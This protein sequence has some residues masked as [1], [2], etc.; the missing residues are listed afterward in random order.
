MKR[1]IPHSQVT[2]YRHFESAIGFTAELSEDVYL[3]PGGRI[4]FDKVVSNIGGKY[5]DEHGFFEGPDDSIYSFTISACFPE[6]LDQSLIT[7]LVFDRAVV[8][9]DQLLF[10]QQH[11]KT[12]VHHL[13]QFSF[14][15]SKAKLYMWKLKIHTTSRIM[16]MVLDL[17]H[18]LVQDS[19][20]LTVMI[21]WH[22]LLS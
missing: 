5:C 20:P 21:M 8:K 3:F 18:S 1:V 11:Q 10:G 9:W 22:S 13:L 14:T 2:A 16:S 19:V 6:Y 12:A 17:L 15:A 7:Q 4:I